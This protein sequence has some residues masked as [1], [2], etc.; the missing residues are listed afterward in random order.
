VREWEVYCYGIAYR[1][2]KT[3]GL[4]DT[5]FNLSSSSGRPNFFRERW[6]CVAVHLYSERESERERERVVLY[7]TTL[8][9]ASIGGN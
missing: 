3:R 2:K 8:L 1:E 4:F 6:S 7:L 5:S 9:V